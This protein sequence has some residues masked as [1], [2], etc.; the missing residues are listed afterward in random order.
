[1]SEHDEPLVHETPPYSILERKLA[2][3]MVV[4]TVVLDGEVMQFERPSTVEDRHLPGFPF[5]D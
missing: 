3:L 5:P 1:M 2:G 4:T